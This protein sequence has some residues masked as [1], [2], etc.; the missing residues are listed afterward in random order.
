M[1]RGCAKLQRG[2]KEQ[3]VGARSS[4]GGVPG[5]VSSRAPRFAPP[6][7][8]IGNL[9]VTPTAPGL[10]HKALLAHMEKTAKAGGLEAYVVHLLDEFLVVEI[11]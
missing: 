6:H 7:V 3:L 10:A 2:A 8:H 9:I 11:A 5:I 1:Q 4:E